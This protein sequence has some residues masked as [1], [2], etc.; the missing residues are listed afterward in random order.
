[1]VLF[2]LVTGRL[3]FDAVHE[4]AVMYEIVN[5]DAPPISAVKQDI[6]PELDRIVLECLD[7]DPDERY[8]SA[9]ELAKDLRRYN[10]SSSGRQRASQVST[11]KPVYQESGVAP[12]A[13]QSSAQQSAVHA[14]A[15]QPSAAQPTPVTA[16]PLAKRSKLPWIVAGV[17]LFAFFMM[18]A[19]NMGWVNFYV[20]RT[21]HPERVTR[22]H[23]LIP[24][25]GQLASW[26]GG[27]IAVSPDGTILAYVASDST[28]PDD[29]L[30]VRQLSSL[31]A[32]KLPGTRGAYYP[33]WSP[34]SKHIG[35]FQD[36]KMMKIAAAGGP[37]LTI[38]EATQGRLGA[39]NEDNTIVFS[40]HFR[41][42]LMRVS[43]AGGIPETLTTMD[44][45]ATDNT[46]RWPWF[47]PD[48]KH[49]LYFAR[50]GSG[51]GSEKDAICVRSLDGTVYKRLVSTAS[52]VAYASGHILYLRSSTLMAHP[53]DANAL[54]F[55]GDAFPIAED[56]SFNNQYSRGSFSVSNNG[57]LVY[58]SGTFVDGS[59]LITYDRT[60][61]VLDTIGEPADMFSFSLS[62]DETHLL[63]DIND[64]NSNQW[65]IWS[66]DLVRGIRTRMTFA[67]ENDG[68]GKWNPNS[69][70]FA[71]SSLRRGDKWSILTKSAN[72]VGEASVLIDTSH[73]AQ[74]WMVDWSSDGNYL[75]YQQV[76]SG[77]TDLNLWAFPLTGDR[78]PIQLT[79]SEFDEDEGKLSPD[80]RWL[81]YTSDES[82]NEEVYVAPF[83]GMGSKWQVSINQGDRPRW[84]NDGKELFYLSNDDEIM[85]ADVDGSGS[86][87]R[88][89]KV[90]R[91]FGTTPQRPGNL[92][93]VY[94]DGQRFIINTNITPTDVSLVTLVVNWDLELP[95]E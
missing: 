58:Q 55:T 34:D 77:R 70:Q 61:V 69:D 82:G 59:L 53:F 3:P 30:W 75:I 23:A 16:T 74:I 11:I 92:Y 47:L 12:A 42:N 48:G 39:W 83:P 37:A 87:F 43:A 93:Q 9:R 41:E 71:F 14:G 5:V 20:N 6:D 25:G 31:T 26:G 4:T 76:D 33:F 17:S 66:L 45:T 68:G 49:Y 81:A 8:Q 24:E 10:R 35:F 62:P 28:S 91:L 78:K 51:S 54:E 27:H 19:A 73:A 29:Y 94:G 52:N 38:C 1:V 84:R 67:A 65:D 60:G 72:G 95:D 50:T 36:G 46:H 63:V 2:E 15:V 90:T 44:T 89:G 18:F 13:H 7:K 56:V 85:A 32:L 40:P 21:S 22:A 79:D 80:G 88:I 86:S 64:A 57:M